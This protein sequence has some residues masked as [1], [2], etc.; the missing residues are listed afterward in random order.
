MNAGA[1]AMSAGRGSMMAGAAAG[2]GASACVAPQCCRP[3]NA[4]GCD[5]VAA[6]LDSD[7]D[8]MTDCVDPA[9]FGYQKRLTLDGAQVAATLSDFPVLI[10]IKDAELKANARATGADIH[11]AAADGTTAL[12]YE[13]EA[14]DGQAGALI[15]WVR[16]PTLRAGADVTLWLQYGDGKPT[17]TNAQRVWNGFRYVWHLA[18]D[19]SGGR[20]G[21]IKDATAR[22]HATAQGNM[23]TM[24]LVPAVAGR[25]L[26]FDG[27]DDQLTFRN[28]FTGSGPCTLSA[29]VNQSDRNPASGGAVIALGNA[30]PNAARFLFSLDTDSGKVDVGFYSNDLAG[31]TLP[32]NVWTHLVWTWDGTNS[33]IYVNGAIATG[34]IAHP[35][36]NTSGNSGRIGN[37][38]F[39]SPRFLRGQLDEVRVAASGRSSG[40][41]ETEYENQRP[42]SDFVR[43]EPEE[44]RSAP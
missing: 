3:L 33:S 2:G 16:I 39:T 25:G 40:W 23:N 22:A 19:P 11:F 1:G 44:P 15:A 28:E 9:P 13:I 34:P 43:V 17:S 5:C 37:S 42:D 14:Y 21:G 4:G 41:I 12:D 6:T 31:P 30:S 18:E 38:F 26:A 8:G 32:T 24:S 10:R 20:S 27:T 29:W 7:S 35:G 36:A